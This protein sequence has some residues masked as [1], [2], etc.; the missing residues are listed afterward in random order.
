MLN[1]KPAMQV[2]TS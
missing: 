2:L 1:T